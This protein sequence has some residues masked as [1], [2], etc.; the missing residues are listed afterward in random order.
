[1]KHLLPMTSSCCLKNKGKTILGLFLTAVVFMAIGVVCPLVYGFNDDVMMR[2]ILSGTYTGTPDGHAVYMRYPLTGI[3]SML[4]KIGRGVPWLTLFFASCVVVCV[5]LVLRLCCVG[6]RQRIWQAGA[7]ILGAEVLFV[8]LFRHYVVMHYT[9]LAAVLS[10]TGIFVL[11]AGRETLLSTSRMVVSLILFAL[12]YMVRTQVFYLSLPF[13]VVALLWQFIA[14]GHTVKSSRKLQFPGELL[15]RCIIF[16]GSLLGMV[17]LFSCFHRVMYGSEEWQAY[18]SYNDARTELY[19][20]AGILPYDSYEQ[21]YEEIGITRTQYEMLQKYDTVLDAE[22]TSE[23]I[24][25]LAQ[26]AQEEK[27]KQITFGQL[28][29]KR[30]EE[31]FYRTLHSVDAPYNLIVLF[32]YGAAVVLCLCSRQWYRLVLIVLTG[33]GRS[34]VW[35]YLMMKGR[36]PE[37]V[38]VALYLIEGLLLAGLCLNLLYAQMDAVGAGH[39]RFR[40]MAGVVTMAAGMLLCIPLM[41]GVAK[42]GCEEAR[43]QK[44]IQEEWQELRTYMNSRQ[45]DFF[46]ID[47]YSVVSVSGMQYEAQEYENYLLLGGWMTRSVLQEEKQKETGFSSPLE[48]MLQGDGV[49]LVAKEEP[50]WL[51]EYAA[52]Q[53]Y[54]LQLF[55][56]DQAG[57][58]SIYCADR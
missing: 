27:A 18:E 17:V 3:L 42:Q 23:Q 13:V 37:R 7:V 10:G 19:D 25:A 39:G 2:S 49:Y 9:V 48:A 46:Y 51:I 34:L 12:C 50:T 33:A 55:L 41:V 43:T 6:F 5:Y 40:K 16:L 4:Y 53:G 30:L 26:A 35:L 38:T 1:M 11:T 36:Y 57:K 32:L 58:F 28:L 56:Y 8:M 29:S 21:I 47:V 22:I 44:Q 31:Y 45:D 15:Q 14:Q 24:A 54:D 52:G 20:Y